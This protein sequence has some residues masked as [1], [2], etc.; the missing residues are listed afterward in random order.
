MTS[1]CHIWYI[2]MF[3]AQDWYALFC[4]SY[5]DGLVKDFN[6]SIADALELLQSCSKPLIS[7]PLD[8]FSLS[9]DH[10]PQ[11]CLIGTTRRRHQMETFSAL[12]AL[13]AGNVPV[14]G[15]FPHKGQWRGAL[16]FFICTWI[17]GWVNTREAGDLR[18]TPSRPLIRHCNGLWFSQCCWIWFILRNRP[19]QICAYPFNALCIHTIW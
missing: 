12:L 7:Y 17:N 5:I 14:T 19:Y 8:A 4:H 18:H 15:E 13:C 1:T 2:F 9:V 16:I 6:N 11:C 10:D 3:S